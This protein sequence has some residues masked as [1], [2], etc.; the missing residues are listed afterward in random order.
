MDVEKIQIPCRELTVFIQLVDS[1]PQVMASAKDADGRYV[2]VNS[3]FAERVGQSREAIVGGRV[4][5]FFAAELAASY[6]A[7]DAAVL[8]TGEPLAGH[9]ELIVRPDRRLGWY[10][11]SKTQLVDDHGAVFGVAV[12][13]VDLHAQMDS[14]HAGLAHAL[15]VIRAR[16]GQTWR[17]GDIATAAGLSVSQLERVCRRTLGLSPRSLLQRLRVE[18]AARLL[19]T[20]DASAA[21]I[22]TE[23]G[24]YDQASFTRQFRAVVGMTPGAFRRI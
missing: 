22:A 7:Q 23:C 17:V 24:F 13:S 19:T 5:D 8:A 15:D 11:T 1:L 3:G 20:T 18:Q 12:L 9:L 10:L 14:A 6:A 21:D 4:A 2:Y 16:I